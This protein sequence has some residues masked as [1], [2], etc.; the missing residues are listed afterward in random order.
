[1]KHLNSNRGTD[2]TSVLRGFLF[3]IL[4]IMGLAF[5]GCQT[6]GYDQEAGVKVKTSIPE[7]STMEVEY[8]F[9]PET[10][11]VETI[12]VLISGVEEASLLDTS[13]LK[14]KSLVSKSEFAAAGKREGMLDNNAGVEGNAKT[15]SRLTEVVEQLDNLIRSI[16]SPVVV[17]PIEVDDSDTED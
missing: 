3:V 1:M 17:P 6:N 10:G 16:K 5:T 7:L 14:S 9:N 13:T 12:K 8:A 11:Q 2:A 15:D 4:A